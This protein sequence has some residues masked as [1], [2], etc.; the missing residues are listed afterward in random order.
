M[1][2]RTGDILFAFSLMT[3]PMSI[4]SALLLGLIF[5][6]KVTPSESGSTDLQVDLPIQGN[7]IYVDISATTLTTVASWSSTIAPIL[8]GCAITLISYPVAKQILRAGQTRR[9][10]R[11]PTPFQLSLMLKMV[12]SGS[13]QA[14]WNWW[15]YFW[16]WRGKKE[17]QGKPMRLMTSILIIGLAL[18]TLVFAADTWFHFT[19]K[20]INLTQVYPITTSLNTSVGLIPDCYHVNE[21]FQG[22]CTLNP[23]GSTTF[24]MQ[25]P[26]TQSVIAN[27]STTM[28]VNTLASEKDVFTYVGNPPK[29]ALQNVDYKSH[30]WGLKTEC[31][32]VTSQ[33]VDEASISGTSLRYKCPFAMEGSI[34]TEAGTAFQNQYRMTY[35]EDSTASSN[36][37]SSVDLT[38]PYFFGAISLVNQ[39]IGHNP[40]MMDDPEIT[41]TT[42]GADVFVL[43]CNTTVYDVEYT[44]INGSITEFNAT[45]AN[46]TLTNIVQGTQQHTKVGDPTLIQD[47]AIAALVSSD[48]Q[49]VADYF[50]MSYSQVAL[51]IAS[52]AFTPQAAIQA[53]RRETM[54]VAKVPIAPLAC[55]LIANLSLVLLGIVLMII[56]AVAARGETRE[57]QARLSVAGLV[58]AQF[59]GR[60]AER[61]VEKVEDLFEEK[62]GV[63][64]SGPRVGVVR[65]VSG[66]WGFGVWRGD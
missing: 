57:V 50:A 51:G 8:V 66:G 10:D 13:P 34:S 4:F 22:G 40:A 56:A 42:H 54:L 48:S 21:T 41:S 44:S 49:G 32:P 31:A 25:G 52:A 20:T 7:V 65:N 37:T 26:Q 9:T 24:L 1:R 27:L 12:T 62:E 5:Y 47:A 3:I 61:V 29:A 45:P 43:F 16:G 30:T 17:T 46:S 59:E 18:S 55:L 28:R 11:L 38:N 60:R 15:Q 2:G 53:Q 19:T 39:N 14:L 6:F 33:C 58:A 35:F 63:S 64:G 36:S 23:G